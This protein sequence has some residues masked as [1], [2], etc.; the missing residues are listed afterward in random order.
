MGRCRRASRVGGCPA[1]GCRSIPQPRGCCGA[2]AFFHSTRRGGRAGRFAAVAAQGFGRS[3]RP[4]RCDAGRGGASAC[5][6]APQPRARGPVLRVLTANLLA[7]RASAE[8]VV[9]LVRRKDVD[10]LFLQELT[11]AA[12][13]QLKQAGLNDLLPHEAT[14]T[15]C[16]NSRGSGIYARLRLSNGLPLTAISAARPTARLELP[17]G[18]S[19]D[20]VCVHPSRPPRRHPLYCVHR[21]GGWRDGG[22]S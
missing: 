18:Q 7:G 15:S 8:T 10:V 5:D 9:G 21:G 6:Q 14:D 20:L 19:V 17:A 1:G 3:H 11:D 22:R 12:V 16:S 2:G 4:C 13:T